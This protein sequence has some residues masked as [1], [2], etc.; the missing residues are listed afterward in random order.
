MD[1]TVSKRMKRVMR[2]W[3]EEWKQRRDGFGAAQNAEVW[4][5]SISTG[6]L[7]SSGRKENE[8]STATGAS[9]LQTG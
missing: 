6:V 7:L 2:C 8:R 4:A 9:H 3:N 5:R 1:P